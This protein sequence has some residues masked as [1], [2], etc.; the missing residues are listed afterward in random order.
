MQL[1]HIPVF[2]VCVITL[3]VCPQV[4]KLIEQEVHSAVKKNESKL[5]TLVE[6][7]EKCDRRVD[8]ERSIRKLEV[9]ASSDAHFY[10]FLLVIG[11]C[12]QN[13]PLF[14]RLK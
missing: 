3:T 12:L 1:H 4:Q 11:K 5:Q 2:T 7:I 14:H 9:G 8:F 13:A 10:L 6:T